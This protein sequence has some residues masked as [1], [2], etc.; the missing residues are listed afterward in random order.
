M[1]TGRRQIDPLIWMP[2]LAIIL[3]L[4]GLAAFSIQT[5]TINQTLA[6]IQRRIDRNERAIRETKEAIEVERKR[7][8]RM[9]IRGDKMDSRSDRQDNRMDTL[10]THKKAPAVPPAA[11]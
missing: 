8:D 9:D 4:F 2:A 1:D 3:G 11:Q 6:D 7:N 5:Y 10:D